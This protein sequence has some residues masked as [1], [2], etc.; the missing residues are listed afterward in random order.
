[1]THTQKVGEDLGYVRQVVRGA[2]TGATP[3]G[4]Y[5]LWAA[6][7]LAGFALADFAPQHMAPYW[8][9]AGPLGF[10]VSCWLGWRHGRVTGQESRAE[11]ARYMLHWGGMGVAIALVLALTVSG[12]LSDEGVGQ[13]IVLIVALSY[14]LAGVHLVP[15]LKWVG[16]L[17]AIGYLAITLLE[18]FAYVWTAAGVLLAIGLVVA[19]RSS[20]SPGEGR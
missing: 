2:E 8:A 17:A 13:A 4:I 18:D 9:I 7:G 15:I 20:G 5:Y 1:M 12:S 11:G 16:L 19:A 6:I 3:A 14:W 10:V